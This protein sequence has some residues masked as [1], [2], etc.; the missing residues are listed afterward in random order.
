MDNSAIFAI[1]VIS[2]MGLLRPYLD[3]SAIFAIS[4]ISAM[5]V[6]RLSTGLF[7]D[8]CNIYNFCDGGSASL[9]WI[10]LRY[11][12]ICDFCN[13]SSASLIWIILRYLQYLRFLR[14]GFCVSH[15]DNSAIF[16]I[17]AIS[18]M[19]LLRP[20]LNNAAIFAV[21][22]ISAMGVLHLSFG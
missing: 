16:A 22:A 18:A 20:Y 9:I 2:S 5:G 19:G 10:I 13:G 21:S 17:S 6:Q 7:Y 8:I 12:H 1:S 15:L 4:A 3:N 11:L 14:W